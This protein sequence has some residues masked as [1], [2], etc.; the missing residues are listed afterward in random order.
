MATG[1]FDWLHTGHIR[2]FEEASA[3][4]ELSVV[5]GHDANIR[6]LKGE[7]HPLIKEEERLYMVASIRFVHSALVSSG[8]GWLDAG[9]EIEML[10]PDEYVVN[11]DGD[12]E[13]KRRYCEEKGIRYVV[14]ERKPRIGLPARSS[15]DL[16]GF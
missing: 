5:V 1:S 11:A 2:F 8:H 16:R 3:R 9:P 7:G 12:K 13:E 4:G 15:T 6:L 14:L 10:G